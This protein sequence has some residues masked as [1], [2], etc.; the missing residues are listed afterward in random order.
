M[1]KA[2]AVEQPLAASAANED[3]DI[4]DGGGNTPLKVRSLKIESSATKDLM[5]A[6]PLPLVRPSS[7]C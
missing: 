1:T 2:V 7:E 5:V 3:R 6:A 4:G